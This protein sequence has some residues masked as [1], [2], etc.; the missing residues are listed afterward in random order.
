MAKFSRYRLVFKELI[1]I[2]WES[3]FFLEVSTTKYY[4]LNLKIEGL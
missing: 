2:L 3:H 1:K 4:V